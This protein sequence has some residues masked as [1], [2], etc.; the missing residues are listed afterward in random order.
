MPSRSSGYSTLQP[1][2]GQLVDFS[3]SAGEA[4]LSTQ[5]SHWKKKLQK[6]T[7]RRQRQ[8][9]QCERTHDEDK[10]TS[11]NL[12]E[13][14][15]AILEI[16]INVIRILLVSYLSNEQGMNLAALPNPAHAA[17]ANVFWLSVA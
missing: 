9:Y 11:Q 5:L 15:P 2:E 14:Q 16:Q 12:I 4:E 8:I 1:R 3:R 17:G 10:K 6:K 13:Q 7:V